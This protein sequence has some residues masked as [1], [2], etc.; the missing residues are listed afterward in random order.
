MATFAIGKILFAERPPVVMT[1]RAGNPSF[2]A[3]EH[4]MLHGDGK[5]QLI[6]LRSIPFRLVAFGAT[7]A[8][9]RGVVGVAKHVIQNIALSGSDTSVRSHIVARAA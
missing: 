2:S 1:T 7:H 4:E 3:P 6:S 9:P 8:L 5:C